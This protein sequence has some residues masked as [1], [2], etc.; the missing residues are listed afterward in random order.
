MQTGAATKPCLLPSDDVQCA[1]EEHQARSR[2][3]HFP[4]GFLPM[5]YRLTAEDMPTFPNIRQGLVD[6]QGR[7]LAE[8]RWDTRSP[9]SFG[10]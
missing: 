3:E 8:A 10:E 7:I 2:A 9:S 6:A 4:V 1:I 5:S